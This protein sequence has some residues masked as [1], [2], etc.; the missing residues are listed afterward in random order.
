[1]AEPACRP[2]FLAQLGATLSG[3][4]HDDVDARRVAVSLLKTLQG[5]L[6]GAAHPGNQGQVPLAAH[7]ITAER[8][9]QWLV[10]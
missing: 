10:Q 8:V 5:Q 6:A 4:S 3:S 1:M 9:V 7:T 2:E